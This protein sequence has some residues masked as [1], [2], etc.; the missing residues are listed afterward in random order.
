M[1]MWISYQGKVPEMMMRAVG[2]IGVTIGT[3]FF[4]FVCTSTLNRMIE[5]RRPD[6]SSKKMARKIE[7][8]AKKLGMP[9]GLETIKNFQSEASATDPHH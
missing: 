1:M 9:T 4:G 5:L 6:S 3:Y 2:S 7:R 8:L